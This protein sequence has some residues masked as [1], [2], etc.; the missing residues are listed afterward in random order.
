MFVKSARTVS[1]ELCW[2]KCLYIAH[3]SCG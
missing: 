2:E 3:I 1:C